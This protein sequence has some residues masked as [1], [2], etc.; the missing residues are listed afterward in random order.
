MF[1]ARE[2]NLLHYK[3]KFTIKFYDIIFSICQAVGV[4][5]KHPLPCPQPQKKLL[6]PVSI[7][8]MFL[9]GDSGIG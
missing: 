3:L 4:Y 9:C 5:M 6:H 8:S 1:S 2:V 7:L